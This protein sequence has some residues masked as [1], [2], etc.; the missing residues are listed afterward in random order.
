[1]HRT[2]NVMFLIFLYFIRSEYRVISP[3]EYFIAGDTDADFLSSFFVIKSDFLAFWLAGLLICPVDMFSLHD[4]LQCS[5]FLKWWANDLLHFPE[6]TN[7]RAIF[8]LKL[9]FRF[10]IDLSRDSAKAYYSCSI[11]L[12]YLITHSYV[13]FLFAHTISCPDWSYVSSV[14]R[15]SPNFL[16]ALV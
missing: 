16:A 15:C 7:L 13:S 12:F 2:T 8:V 1:M 14:S 10:P 9:I 3:M 11:N 4:R 6:C 5:H